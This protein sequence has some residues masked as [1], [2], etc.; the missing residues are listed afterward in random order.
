MTHSL[1]LFSFPLLVAS[2]AALW[3]LTGCTSNYRLLTKLS[4]QANTF[5]SSLAAEYQSFAASELQEGRPRRADYYATK[6]ISALRG[7]P[8]APEK[9]KGI[10]H[11]S[12]SQRQQL[13]Q[14]RDN[15]L[16]SSNELSQRVVPQTAA[17]AQVMF[18]CWIEQVRRHSADKEAIADCRQDFRESL[19]ELEKVQASVPELSSTSPE[20]LAKLPL[21]YELFFNP[22]QSRPDDASDKRLKEVARFVEDIRGYSITATGVAITEQGQTPPED[23]RLLA[24]ARAL[25]VRYRL[26]E[27]G[28][29]SANILVS[30]RDVLKHENAT[31]HV[32]LAVK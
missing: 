7:T 15:L 10:S 4:P 27:L 20:K 22:A 31:P 14:A 32:E 5:S 1:R 25:T 13:Q 11:A 24:M 12:R 26:I 16:A 23:A 17:R 2:L 6:G 28:I 21:R 3:L 18:D 30:T 29:P 9:L 8:P 19:E